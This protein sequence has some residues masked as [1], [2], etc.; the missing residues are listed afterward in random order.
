MAKHDDGG[1]DINDE[2]DDHL[3]APQL[4]LFFAQAGPEIDDDYP[5]AVQAVI[6]RT[7]V[8][9][10]ND[11][12]LKEELVVEDQQR[13]KY[14]WAKGHEKDVDNMEGKKDEYPQTRDPVEHPGNLPF[15]TPVGHRPEQV[16]DG[17]HPVN[18]LVTL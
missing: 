16:C 12:E 11:Q 10:K 7:Q 9:A 17:C 1:R 13:L 6:K 2:K 18:L 3:D 5:H 15:T 14:L 8:Q 4:G